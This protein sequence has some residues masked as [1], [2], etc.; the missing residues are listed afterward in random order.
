MGWTFNP[1]SARY[2]D[3]RGRFLSVDRALGFVQQALDASGARSATLAQLYGGGMLRGSDWRNAMRQEIKTSYI[4][5]YLAG[6]GGRDQMTQAHWGRIGGLLKHQ[7]GFLEGFT[8]E[9]GEMSEAQIR[10]R[11]Q[12]YVDGA[13]QAYERATGQRMLKAGFDASVDWILGP[14]RTE[15]CESCLTWSEMG[16][17]TPGPNGGF[18]TIDG[19]TFPGDGTSECLGNCKCHLEHENVDGELFGA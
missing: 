1:R 18:P 19:E 2:H 13:R 11:A 16:A 10:A 15:H 17:Q 5:Q 6:I 3:D 14:V 7:Y 9:L 12:I 8:G 4:Q